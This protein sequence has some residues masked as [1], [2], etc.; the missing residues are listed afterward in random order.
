MQDAELVDRDGMIEGSDTPGRLP[1]LT[2]T[3]CLGFDPPGTLAS[4]CI[5]SRKGPDLRRRSPVAVSR[6]AASLSRVVAGTAQP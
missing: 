2:H 5:G 1:T 4:A 6:N 3:Y